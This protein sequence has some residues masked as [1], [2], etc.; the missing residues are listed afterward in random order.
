MKQE[1]KDVIFRILKTEK[2]SFIPAVKLCP[3]RRA[4]NLSNSF[5]KSSKRC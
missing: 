3:I 2:N 5:H 4:V 1:K